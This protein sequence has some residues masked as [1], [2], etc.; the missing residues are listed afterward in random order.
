MGGKADRKQFSMHEALQDRTEVRLGS[1]RTFGIV[2]AVVFA[3]IGLLPWVSSGTPRYWS[4]VVGGIFLAVAYFIPK[5]LAPLNRLWF[6]F[7]LLLHRIVNPIIMGLIFYLVVTPT[8]LIMRLLGKDLLR[9]R[10]DPQAESYW[11]KREPPGP[12]GSSL[13]NQF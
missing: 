5:A 8:G 10:F 4:L 6:Q 11:I 9:L 1:E 13:K 2:F 3:I 7:G 12:D